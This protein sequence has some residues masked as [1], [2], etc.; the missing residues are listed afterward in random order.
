[1]PILPAQPEDYV[2]IQGGMPKVEQDGKLTVVTHDYEE[3]EGMVVKSH[4]DHGTVILKTSNGD[5]EF[6]V[7]LLKMFHGDPCEAQSRKV[8]GEGYPRMKV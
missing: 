2:E 7:D 1:M 4:L 5:R 6:K 3:G 8:G